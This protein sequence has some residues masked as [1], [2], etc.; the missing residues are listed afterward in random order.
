M[1][2]NEDAEKV[3]LIG[4][5]IRAAKESKLQRRTTASMT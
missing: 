1:K 3:T 5:I 2:K 4:A